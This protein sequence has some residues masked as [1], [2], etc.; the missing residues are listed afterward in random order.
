MRD[1]NDVENCQCQLEASVPYPV[2]RE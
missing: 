2:Q 1:E